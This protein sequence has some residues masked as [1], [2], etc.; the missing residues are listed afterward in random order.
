MN[1]DGL[2]K[3]LEIYT[4]IDSHS[5]CKEDV[6]RLSQ[7]IEKECGAMGFKTLRY[8]QTAVGDFLEV[9]LGNGHKKILLLGHLDTVFPAGTA[10]ERPFKQVGNRIYG[11]GI[12]DMK[13]G[14]A[15]LLKAMQILT[16][17]I[18]QE[19]RITAFLTSDEET[20][21]RY[22]EEYI[23]DQASS[24][25]AVL[26]FEGAKPG[27]LTTERKGIVVFNMEIA[28]IAA[29]SGV[30]YRLG[31]SAIEEMAYKIHKLYALR[32]NDREV[33]VNIGTMNGGIASNIIAPCA[34]ITGEVRYFNPDDKQF[35]MDSLSNIAEEVN[36]PGTCTKRYVSSVRPPLAA[37]EKCKR[38]FEIAREEAGMLGRQLS[39]RK[40][41][42]GGDAAFAAICGI[43]S[44]DGLGPEGENSHI[45]SEF[46]LVDSLFFKVEL[47][48]RLLLKI[49]QGA[50][51][52]LP[53]DEDARLKMNC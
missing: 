13:G 46:I 28:G 30:N 17:D 18:H 20:G 1:T 4:N 6:D 48:V 50:L 14:I 41:G 7:V 39:P 27:T 35:I 43:P 16:P 24:S 42:G 51:S 47:T 53:I 29:H 8:P 23:K 10:V 22:S 36:V 40:T 12:L 2:L 5:Y 33:T 21:S 38:L 45:E 3:Q 44:L 34:K 37:D 9:T 25:V 19:Y 11:P 15:T 26:S 31:S 52:S 49:M 32:D